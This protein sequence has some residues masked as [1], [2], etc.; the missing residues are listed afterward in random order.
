MGSGGR[1]HALAW[2]L[3]QNPTLDRLYA[4][5]GNPG[6][7]DVG[8]LVPIAADDIRM[9]AEFAEREHI[10]LTVVGPEAPLVAG[11]ADE[12][13]SR[14][15]RVFGPTAA[16]ATIEG[17]K[18]FCREFARRHDIPM[19]A[20]ESFD[21]PD[22]AEDFARSL[23]AP[24]VVKADGLAV[25]KGVLICGDHEQAVAAIGTVMRE[26]AFGAAGER[27]V[28]EEFLEGREVTML[29]LTDG[30]TLIVFEPAQDFKRSHDGDEGTNTGGM[31]AYSPLPWLTEDVREQAVREI[32]QPIVRGMAEE[33][34]R[35]VG[36]L[37]A[38]LMMTSKGPKL[39]E[40]NCRFGDPE[41]Q[42]VLPRFGT[43]SS[44]SDFAEAVLACVEG[45]L[46]NYRVTWRR[47]ASVCVAVASGG[48]PGPYKT[49]V[50]IEGVE[51]AVSMPG[52]NVFHAGTAM[53][54]R[55]LVSAGGRVLSVVARGRTIEAA[56][57]RA[58]EAVGKIRM[59][60]MHYRTDIAKGVK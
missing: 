29:A 34:R 41:T 7:A 33:D 50:P 54:G 30:E 26:K 17:S 21:D 23:D 6:I 16:A 20:G 10:D 28:V 1:E 18:V 22:A 45:N 57:K 27:V 43:E 42:V 2:K 5:P 3:A 4:A 53:K 44:R 39:I 12:F 11:I 58:Y 56:R 60:G 9:L 14:G 25:G 46:R 51:D 19:A 47:D 24:L 37:Y 32:L 31:G 8:T 49:G 55:K 35:Y 36:C 40:V 38:G 52:V 59:E 13:G 15:L 48:Y